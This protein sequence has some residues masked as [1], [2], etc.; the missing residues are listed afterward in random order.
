MPYGITQCYLPPG[1]GDI[2]N[3]TLLIAYYVIWLT[4]LDLY[5]LLLVTVAVCLIVTHKK[6]P[7]WTL[8]AVNLTPSYIL[9]ILNVNVHG[10][11]CSKLDELS[12]VFEQNSVGIACITETWLKPTVSDDV[13]QIDKYVCHRKDRQDGRDGGGVLVYER[14]DVQCTRLHSY[15][16]NNLETVWLLCH[17]TRMPRC[18]SHILIGAVYHPPNANHHYMLAYIIDC[19]DQLSKDHQQL[20]IILLGDFNSIVYLM[21]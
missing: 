3:L 5:K 9:N 21:Q 17:E 11:L 7:N 6:T 20:G 14:N 13:I 18:L 19:L 8:S 2:R 15:E 10:S 1:R 16:S 12:T 4:L